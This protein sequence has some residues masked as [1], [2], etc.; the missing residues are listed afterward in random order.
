MGNRDGT[1]YPNTTDI[2]GR[3]VKWDPIS[4]KFK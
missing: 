1:V 3:N 4:Q 2:M